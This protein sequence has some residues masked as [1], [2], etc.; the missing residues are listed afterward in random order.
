MENLYD[1]RI[2]A[3]RL[4]K[5]FRV[6]WIV[7][8]VVLYFWVANLIVLLVCQYAEYGFTT[9][10]TRR[11]YA[12]LGK[13]REAPWVVFQA[14]WM[15]LKIFFGADVHKW[16]VFIPWLSPAVFLWF[17]LAGGLKNRKL[18]DPLGKKYSHWA[19]GDEV[20]R[21]PISGGNLMLLGL[22]EGRRLRLSRP[23]N[24]LVWGAS[25]QGKT[26]TVAVPSILESGMASVVAVDINGDLAR[27]TSGHRA[28]LG[29]V[30]CF[31]W[32]K[33]DN[34]A[35]GVFW[36]RWNPLSEKDMPGKSEKRELYLRRL[37]EHLLPLSGDAHW[38]A[39]SV[40]AVEA[41]LNFF[42]VKFEQAC[43]NDY[44]LT[45]LLKKG[46]FSADE[47]KI[48][49]SYYA[50][51]D[52]R[53]AAAAIENVTNKTTGEENYLPVG[54][55]NGV[56]ESWQGKELCLPMI[57]DCLLQK[58]LKMR[59][60]R[61]D[62]V[63]AD[64]CTEYKNEALLF[65]YG[66]RIVSM[67]DDILAMKRKARNLLFAGLLAPLEIFQNQAIRERTSSSDFSLKYI[68]GMRQEVSGEWQLSTTY[69]TAGSREAAFM[70]R[71]MLD[72][73]IERNLEKHKSTSRNVLAVVID[74]LE[75]MPK[76][77]SLCRGMVSGAVANMAFMLLTDSMKKLSEVYGKDVVEE[78]TAA[79]AC[80]LV[81]ANDNI[82]LSKQFRE[83]AVYGAKSV[84]IPAGELKR[85]GRRK[86][87]LSDAAY[88]RK[89]A[90]ELIN[91]KE[92][93]DIGRGQH[94]LL[95][96]GF[97]NLPVK[98]DV[99]TFEVDGKLS[100][101]AGK[102]PH[103]FLDD[104]LVQKRNRQDVDVPTIEEV[105]GGLAQKNGTGDAFYQETEAELAVAPVSVSG[106][107]ADKAVSD[108]E[109]TEDE[110]WMDDKAF[111]LDEAKSENPVEDK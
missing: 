44:L 63:W 95:V 88:Y 36:P 51:M 105:L 74:D 58:Y 1:K 110:W 65:G 103:C 70:T 12:F 57:T 2:K 13:V 93:R 16:T 49:L 96:G 34:P 106:S 35:E 9:K 48:L 80:K 43:A 77:S 27:Y 97:Y 23:E 14:Y 59:E 11:V 20:R 47:E 79:A 108:I 85:G 87:G 86:Q 83:L 29:R 89:I 62:D 61:P 100:I 30:F 38:Q 81:F 17:V 73:L 3:R 64:I 92:N 66:G 28:G 5:W 55:W 18:F 42:V 10:N 104:D 84:Q 15:W 19:R 32:D 53:Y 52:Q 37:A 8:C 109:E 46:A 7:L 68:R 90:D 33:R 39:L 71:L 75:Q 4:S 102:A 78:M 76:F 82:E 107:E 31:D 54:S 21:M 56:P 25:A 94:V 40:M 60:S 22:H 111:T 6:L 72:M 67:F 24:V 50:S 101:L 99:K 26:S 45:Q 91:Q 98:V 41:V 69:L